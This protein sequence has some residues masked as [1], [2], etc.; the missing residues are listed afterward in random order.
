MVVDV[1]LPAMPRKNYQQK[2]KYVWNTNLSEEVFARVLLGWCDHE[3]ATETAQWVS[4]WA[5]TN[6]HKRITRE[7]VS[8]YFIELGVHLWIVSGLGGFL[9]GQKQH[10]PE[11]I[12]ARNWVIAELEKLHDVFTEKYSLKQLREER[13]ARGI[14]WGIDANIPIAFLRFEFK[15]RNA[16]S[17]KWMHIYVARAFVMSALIADEGLGPEEASDR[18]CDWMLQLLEMY[19][20]RKPLPSDKFLWTEGWEQGLDAF[21]SDR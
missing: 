13:E 6:G 18:L 12:E 1:N 16:F 14:H 11:S 5:L 10:P 21:H 9:R 19:P 4:D 8:R 7:T 3:S 2:N 17:K 15:R 20:L